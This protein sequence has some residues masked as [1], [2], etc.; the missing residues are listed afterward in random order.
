MSGD[1]KAEVA[2]MGRSMDEEVELVHN[3]IRLEHLRRTNGKRARELARE[4]STHARILKM[5]FDNGETGTLI[6]NLTGCIEIF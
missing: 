3:K 4:G 2:G 1:Y 5:R 6:T